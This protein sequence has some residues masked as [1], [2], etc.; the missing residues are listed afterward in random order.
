VGAGIVPPSRA[1]LESIAHRHGAL[2]LRKNR[3]QNKKWCNTL[4][5]IAPIRASRSS[6][7]KILLKNS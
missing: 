1:V 4:A 7:K 2:W 6:V 3:G 5:G